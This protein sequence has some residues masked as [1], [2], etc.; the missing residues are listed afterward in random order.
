MPSASSLQE[1]AFSLYVGCM[2]CEN[3]IAQCPGV[4]K[5]IP[6]GVPPRGFRFE[7]VPIKVLVVGKNPGH[8]LEGERDR[9]IGLTGAALL[10]TYRDFQGSYYANP[11]SIREPSNRFHKR[12][13][14]YLGF[15]L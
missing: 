3:T 10:N 11:D 2:N 8:P 15:F 7:A 13:F 6:L 12:L 5:D 4:W 1:R 9:F 14:R